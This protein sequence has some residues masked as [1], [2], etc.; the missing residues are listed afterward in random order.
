MI[1]RFIT[2]TTRLGNSEALQLNCLL[3]CLVFYNA[4]IH[5]IHFSKKKYLEQNLQLLFKACK[6]EGKIHSV[7]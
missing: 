1:H 6:H 3:P 4:L 2:E 7:V 5:S